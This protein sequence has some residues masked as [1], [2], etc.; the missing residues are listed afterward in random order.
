MMILAHTPL[1]IGCQVSK[2][3]KMTGG[4]VV[5]PIFANLNSLFSTPPVEKG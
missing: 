5:I 3:K 2:L 4:G 1:K